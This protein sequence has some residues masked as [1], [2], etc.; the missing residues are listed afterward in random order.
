MTIYSLLGFGMA[1]IEKCSPVV[2]WLLSLL[3]MVGILSGSRVLPSFFW[4][5]HTYKVRLCTYIYICIIRYICVCRLDIHTYVMQ[6]WVWP[7]L[8]G[9]GDGV[10]F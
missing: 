8:W 6:M 4:G 5:G 1:R 9:V 7:G 10:G 2:A 3:R